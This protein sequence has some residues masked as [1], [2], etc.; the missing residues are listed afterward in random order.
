MTGWAEFAA[1]LATFFLSHAI[2]VRSPLRPWLVARLG[3]RGY[4]VGYSLVS[5]AVLAWLIGAAG[6]APHVAVIPPLDLLRWLPVLV[7]PL[8]CWLVVAGLAVDNPLSIGG[9]GRGARNPARRGVLALTRHPLLLALALWALAHLLANG[10]L[11]HVILFGLMA[12]FAALGMG[13]IDR[14]KRRQMG[15]AAWTRAA[16]GT[17]RL[18]LAGMRH[19]RP[20]AGQLGLAL[21][22]Y[23]GLWLLHAPVIGVSSWP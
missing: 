1:A 23:A 3:M 9:P 8:V 4:L 22:L 17:A 14:R 10:D 21:A 11:A 18:S 5:L 16:A 7:M 6:R 12:G 19:L 2:P 20:S 15:D 13:L